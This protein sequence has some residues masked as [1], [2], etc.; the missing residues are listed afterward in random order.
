MDWSNDGRTILLFRTVL[1]T[2]RDF[3]SV[4]EAADLAAQLPVLIRGIFYEGWNPSSTPARP[5]D[6]AAFMA[7]VHRA[8]E[9]QPLD[10]PDAAVA[11]VVKLL[12]RHVTAGEMGHVRQSMRKDLRT[13]FPEA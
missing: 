13:I 3:L 9:R 1:H 12:N 10:D 5:R 6:K 2:I 7:R 11:A 8:F 4:D